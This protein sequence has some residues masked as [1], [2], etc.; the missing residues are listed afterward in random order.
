[1]MR[2]TCAPSEDRQRQRWA[3]P[4]PVSTLNA[5]RQEAR[6]RDLDADELAEA[7]LANVVADN[8]YA[9]IVDR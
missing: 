8:L 4:S 9:A 5:L 2:K 6:R 7:I 3:L 1:M